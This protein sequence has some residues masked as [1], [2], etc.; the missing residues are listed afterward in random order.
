MSKFFLC[1]NVSV[2][3]DNDMVNGV[4]S[5]E[6]NIR[7]STVVKINTGIA[8][9]EKKILFNPKYIKFITKR[10]DGKIIITFDSSCISAYRYHIIIGT[11]TRIAC[12]SFTVIDLD[13]ITSL[14]YEQFMNLDEL[15]TNK[16][17]NH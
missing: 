7:S 1:N 13:D 3:L 16:N 8:S 11:D 15:Y 5:S 17:A 6:T 12:D 9:Q 14:D 2:V 10:D 4:A